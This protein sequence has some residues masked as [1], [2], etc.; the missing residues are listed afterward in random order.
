MYE[1]ELSKLRQKEL[2]KEAEHYRIISQV[3]RGS[4]RQRKTL[5]RGLAWWGSILSRWGRILQERF[6]D[7]GLVE[8]SQVTN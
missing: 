3:K 1:Y 4:S 5:A 7:S 8:N 2:L 6:G